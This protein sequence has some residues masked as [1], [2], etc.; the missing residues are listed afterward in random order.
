MSINR[1]LQAY[2]AFCDFVKKP[3]SFVGMWPMKDPGLIYRLSPYVP[4]LLCIN[5]IVLI[6]NGVIHN[7]GNLKMVTLRLTIMVAYLLCG[8]KVLKAPYFH[9]QLL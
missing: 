6:L 4:L 3:L 5:A 8:V 2:V 1:K 9:H 7:L